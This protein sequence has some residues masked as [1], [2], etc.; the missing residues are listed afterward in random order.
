MISNNVKMKSP[1]QYCDIKPIGISSPSD[2]A[3]FITNEDTFVS[4]SDR[5]TLDGPDDDGRKPTY[6]SEVPGYHYEPHWWNSKKLVLRETET[7]DHRHMS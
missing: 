1:Q 7:N 4:T 3:P 2:D 6:P 5:F